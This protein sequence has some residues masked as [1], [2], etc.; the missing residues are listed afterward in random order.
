VKNGV[1]LPRDMN[2]AEAKNQRG[3]KENDPGVLVCATRD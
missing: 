1:T 2:V 3:V